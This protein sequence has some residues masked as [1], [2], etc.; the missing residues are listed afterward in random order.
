MKLEKN[1]PVFLV[2]RGRKQD[3]LVRQHNS[4]HHDQE[5]DCSATSIPQFQALS[6]KLLHFKS[7]LHLS[8]C[9]NK[10]PNLVTFLQIQFKK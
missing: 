1:W 8:T 3:S 10:I 6:E 9:A 2:I 4:C 5:A 7:V